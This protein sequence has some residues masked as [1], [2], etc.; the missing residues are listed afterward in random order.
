ME[1]YKFVRKY[2]GEFMR[3]CAGYLGDEELVEFLY[4]ASCYLANARGKTTRAAEP[5][6][7]IF[8]L[9]NVADPG[10]KPIKEESSPGDVWPEWW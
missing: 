6:A 10:A 5:T 2:D 9:D 1:Q 4:R 7:Y 3:W 8:V